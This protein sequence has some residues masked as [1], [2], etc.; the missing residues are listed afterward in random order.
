MEPKRFVEEY[1]IRSLVCCFSGGRSSLV[2]THYVLSQLRDVDVDKYVVHVDTGVMVPMTEEY[3]RKVAD[4]YGWP[5]TVLKPEVDYWKYAARYGTPSPRRRWC[6]KYLKLKP[7]SD[8]IRR[9]P[10]QRAELLGFRADEVERRRRIPQVRYRKKTK[11]W[12]Y[13]PIRDWTMRDVL[14]YIRKHGLPDPPHYRLGLRE[15]CLCGVFAHKKEWMIIKA[16]FPDLFQ[17]FVELEKH[18]LKWGRTAFYDGGPLSAVELNK[19]STL[20]R[21]I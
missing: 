17:K 11:S 1:G 4:L 15:T 3:V 20:D 12:V 5:L 10:P 9:L 19:Q 18:R 16:H 13:L 8:F 2:M 6:C 21:W 7:I 14:N